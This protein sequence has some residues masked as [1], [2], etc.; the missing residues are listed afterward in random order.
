MSDSVERQ[1]AAPGRSP[2][3][4]VV[5]WLG[6]G[7]L[8]TATGVLLWRAATGSGHVEFDVRQA[9]LPCGLA[10]L[11]GGSGLVRPGGSRRAA[12]CLI[13]ASALLG[14]TAFLLDQFNLLVEVHRWI[15][16]GMP[17]PWQ[18]GRGAPKP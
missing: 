7:L 15:D 4:G 8:L 16:R 2:V 17:A 9:W 14:A 12:M 18:W 3:T 1:P 5:P 10:C 6:V 11:W 13:A